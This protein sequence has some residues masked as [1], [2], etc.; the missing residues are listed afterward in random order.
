MSIKP[1]LFT[2]LIIGLAANS[3]A[4]N[5]DI[6]GETLIENQLI[7]RKINGAQMQTYEINIPKNWSNSDLI[8]ESYLTSKLDS[9]T[10]PLV[11]ISLKPL[12]T[13]END[14][15]QW[16]CNQLGD[17]TCFLPAKYIEPSKTVFIGVFCKNCEYSVKYT[18]EKETSLKLGAMNLFH[19][20]AGDSKVFDLTITDATEFKDY[21]NISSLNLK[22]TKYEMKVEIINNEDKKSSPIT[23]KVNSSWIG[24]QQSLIYPKNFL[25]SGDQNNNLMKYSFKI[26]ISAHENGVFNLE[27]TS[28]NTIVALTE[29]NLNMRFDSA[30]NNAPT[31]YFY[32]AKKNDKVYINVKSIHGE[33]VIRTQEN[34]KP[35]FDDFSD[36]FSVTDSKEEKIALKTSSTI[37]KLY[38]CVE[39]QTTSYYTINIFS[40]SNESSVNNYKKLL[41]SK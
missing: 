6:K 37:E 32:N 36:K 2:L 15:E 24:G 29:S 23:A 27:A 5:L 33:V 28:G 20:K 41:M 13:D 34:K 4:T 11:F 14:S 1:I 3:I 31:C 16:I 19:L 10:S 17:E 26:I 8:V 22:Q 25:L 7:T 9:K 21:I 40:E 12:S 38:L 30:T 39:S 35:E 18:F